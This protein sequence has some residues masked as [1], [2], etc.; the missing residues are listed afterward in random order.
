MWEPCHVVRC[1]RGCEIIHAC[2]STLNRSFQEFVMIGHLHE[3]EDV[4]RRMNAPK[5][6]PTSSAQQRPLLDHPQDAIFISTEMFIYF[7][8]YFLTFPLPSFLVYLCPEK[9]GF[10]NSQQQTWELQQVILDDRRGEKLGILEK[11]WVIWSHV[12]EII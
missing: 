4:H 11:L 2:Q 5:L 10:K 3:K 1:F 12:K 8:W 6:L 7:W 9:A